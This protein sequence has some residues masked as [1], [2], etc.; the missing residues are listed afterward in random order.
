MPTSVA[1]HIDALDLVDVARGTNPL[2][3]LSLLPFAD[4]EGEGMLERYALPPSIVSQRSC[5]RP[6]SPSG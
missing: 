6:N 2:A 4:I 5:V 1:C 3:D